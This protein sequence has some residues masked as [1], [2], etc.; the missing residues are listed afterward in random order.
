MSEHIDVHTIL[1]EAGY[2][3]SCRTE[4]GRRYVREGYTVYHSGHML[5][6]IRHGGMTRAFPVDRL[7]FFSMR[8]IERQVAIRPSGMYYR[9][10]RA[11][12][13]IPRRV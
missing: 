8:E 5:V 2:S 9:E 10:E 1:T 11:N 3:Y 6:C 12:Y 7:E 13:D 4:A